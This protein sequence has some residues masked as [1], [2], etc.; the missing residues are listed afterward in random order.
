MGTIDLE[1]TCEEITI[2]KGYYDPLVITLD[3]VRKDSL[4]TKEIAE[5][6]SIEN[7]FN[8]YSP[9]EINDHSLNNK[10]YTKQ[11]FT[12]NDLKEAFETGALGEIS[13]EKYIQ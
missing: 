13:W 12:F 10:D 2:K 5:C 6:I 7:F 3:N 4:D 8:V 1:L 11:L 9:E